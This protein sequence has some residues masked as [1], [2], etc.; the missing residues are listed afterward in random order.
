VKS[1]G[2][3]AVILR[4]PHSG[5][6]MAVRG[7]WDVQTIRRCI[8]RR[9]PCLCIQLYYNSLHGSRTGSVRFHRKLAETTRWLHWNCT[10]VVQ[11][12]RSLRTDLSRSVPESP[13]KKI[14]R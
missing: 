1:H 2:Y 8:C 10:I 12:P 9:F 13:H 3:R 5:R 7:P 11:S 14:V 6:T 4:Q